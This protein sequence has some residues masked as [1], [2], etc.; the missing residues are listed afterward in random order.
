MSAIPDRRILSQEI[1]GE[2][3]CVDKIS[4]GKD[5]NMFNANWEYG[6]HYRRK[7]PLIAQN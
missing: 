5:A 4:Y 2:D 6:W 1:G 7:I 3:F